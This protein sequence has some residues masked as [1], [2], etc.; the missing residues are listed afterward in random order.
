MHP[1]HAHLMHHVVVLLMF[2]GLFSKEEC[3]NLMGLANAYEGMLD[4]P[5]QVIV[6]LF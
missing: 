6:T 2:M 5:V 1:Q 3:A 4:Q